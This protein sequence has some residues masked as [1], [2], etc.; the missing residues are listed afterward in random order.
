MFVEWTL[1][2]KPEGVLTTIFHEMNRPLPIVG[3]VYTDR[4]VG[5]LFV[6]AIAGQTLQTIKHLVE[7]GGEQ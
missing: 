2:E 4:I 6:H 3:N 7:S 1:E 5:P